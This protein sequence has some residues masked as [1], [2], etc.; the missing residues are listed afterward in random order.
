MKIAMIACIGKNN[1]LGIN[2]HLI[3]SLPNDLEFFKK[4]TTGSIVVMGR[5]TFESLPRLLPNR[6]NIVISRNLKRNDIEVYASINKFID[7]YKNCNEQI[8][9]IGGSSIYKQFFEYANCLYL[10]LVDSE[11]NEADTYFPAFNKDEWNTTILG[12]NEDYDISYKHVLFKR[13]Q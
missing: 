2:N 10:T 6:K 4:I 11:Y 9:I 7:K 3:W 5:K 12:M 13:K 1:E 8:F